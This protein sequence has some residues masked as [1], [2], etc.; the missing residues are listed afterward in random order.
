MGKYKKLMQ[1]LNSKSESKR[2]LGRPG[3]SREGNIKKWTLKA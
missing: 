1:N 3:H 2:P